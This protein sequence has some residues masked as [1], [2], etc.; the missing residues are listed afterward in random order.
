MKLYKIRF[1]FEMESRQVDSMFLR[2]L[3]KMLEIILIDLGF[4]DSHVRILT[5]EVYKTGWLE[6]FLKI[7]VA[8]KNTS[9]KQRISTNITSKK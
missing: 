7:V 4:E 1:F 2:E 8:L 3:A 6:V 9:Q 5:V